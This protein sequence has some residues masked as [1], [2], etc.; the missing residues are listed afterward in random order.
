[1]IRSM[2]YLFQLVDGTRMTRTSG[3]TSCRRRVIVGPP[4]VFHGTPWR[5]DKYL[6]ER[7]SVLR[8]SLYHTAIK[9]MY[10]YFV[11]P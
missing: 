1:M 9:Y 4:R 10:T 11:F 6:L 5:V 7:V 8:N 3:H 2:T